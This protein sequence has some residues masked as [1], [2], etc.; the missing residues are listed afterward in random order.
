MAYPANYKYTREHEWIDV[1][2]KTGTIGITD[3]A[4]D[5]LGDQAGDGG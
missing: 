3:H 2:G 1:S 4:Q 5:S